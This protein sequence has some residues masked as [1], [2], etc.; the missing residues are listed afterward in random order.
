MVAFNLHSA[1]SAGFGSEIL[2]YPNS[3][4]TKLGKGKREK[5]KGLLGVLF[6][7]VLDQGNA[8]L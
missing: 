3:K 5:E 7:L 4:E 2:H 1:L 8:Y 6:M